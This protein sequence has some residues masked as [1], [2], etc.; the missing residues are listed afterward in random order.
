[1]TRLHKLTGG[2]ARAGHQASPPCRRGALSGSTALAGIAVWAMVGLTVSLSLGTSARAQTLPTGGSVV[3][4]GAT[5]TTGPGTVTINQSTQTTAINW[6]SFSIGQG[7]S[8]VF[9]QPNSRSAALNRVLGADA[10]AIFGSL[11]SNGQVFLI[12]PNGVLFGQ[13]S[14]VSVG[15]LVASTLGMSDADFMAGDYRFSGSGGTVLNQGTIIADGGYAALLGGHVSNEGLIQAN[16]GTIALV[17]GDAVTLDVA[18]DGLLNVAVDRGAANALVQNGGMLQADGG[19]VL[20][21]AQGAGDLLRTVV[22]T[23][24]VI[25]ARTIGERNG[26]I[27]LLG[28]MQSGTVNVAGVLDA[29][30]PDGG[31]GGF[32]DTSARTVNIAAAT[33]IT[34]EAPSGAAGTWLIDPA[35]FTIGAGGNISGATLSAQLVTTN[36]VISTMTGP[37]AALPGN[38]DIHVN[39]AIAWTASSTPTT[40]T[41]NANRDV[42]INAAISATNG[43]LVACCGRDVNVNAAITTV[44]GSVLLNAGQNVNVYHAITTT[45][46]NIALC[47]GHDVHIDAAVTLTRGST[48][49]AQSLGLPVGL[50][51]IAGADGT[52]PGVGGGTIIFSPLAPPITVTVAP[53]SI[54]Y[55]P[56]SYAAPSD[57]RT[58]F[59]LTE[60]AALSQRML[61][62]PDGGRAFNG[63]TATTLNGFR[64]TAI[65]GAP[66]GVTLVAGPAATA[67]FD[68]A[69]AGADVGI[70]YSGYTLAGANADQYALAGSCCV[71]TFRTRGTIS[72]TTVTPPVVPPVVPPVTPPVTPPPVTPPGVPPFVSPLPTVPYPVVTPVPDLALDLVD[73]GV[74]MPP[75]EAP[76]AAPPVE[77]AIAAPAPATRVA[78]PVP[79]YVRKQDRN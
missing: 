59:I 51:L 34:T 54:F 55:N 15:G 2:V 76:T 71:G 42:N 52:G 49:P 47:A 79:V 46:G 30:A 68:S 32:I 27:L 72:S 24:G 57:F 16:L 26:V 23:T 61:L 45:D 40:L 21:T 29:S 75:Y 25:Q 50:T 7:G 17:A 10:S 70:T 20:M 66:T 62:F 19:R 8:V 74:R 12:N 58:R 77:E 33:R 6:Q 4:G 1:M 18:G 5:I 22:N 44:N 11:T 3:A 14:Q 9:V 31:D 35:D 13:G 37:G 39:D 67:T 28:D 38:G 36:V 60:G 56:A 69:A 43:N 53:V 65:S 64:T 78:P 73:R 48:I 63:T 41:L